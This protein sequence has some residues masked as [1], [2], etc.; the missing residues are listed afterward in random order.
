V[1]QSSP[2]L[3]LERGSYD[4][5][6]DATCPN[7]DT[8]EFTLPPLHVELGVKAYFVLVSGWPL[9]AKLVSVP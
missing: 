3:V 6:V 8:K 4:I 5:S 9:R 1:S 7:A 2:A